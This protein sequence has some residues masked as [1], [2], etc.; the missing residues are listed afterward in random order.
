MEKER[1]S[2]LQTIS[3]FLILGLLTLILVYGVRWAFFE[4][5]NISIPTYIESGKN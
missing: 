4:P 2:D 5:R 1:K 3:L